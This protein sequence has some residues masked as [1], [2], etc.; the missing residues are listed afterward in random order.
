MVRGR[1]MVRER[2][3]GR[4][5]EWGCYDTASKKHLAWCS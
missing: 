1:E 5:R 4:G 3:R 2:V